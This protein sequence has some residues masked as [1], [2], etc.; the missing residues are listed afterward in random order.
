MTSLFIFHFTLLFRT[1][2]NR[3][4]CIFC[5][6]SLFQSFYCPVLFELSQGVMTKL[7]NGPLIHLPQFFPQLRMVVPQLS[8]L[9]YPLKRA[10]P[11]RA[12]VIYLI[13]AAPVIPAVI[14]YFQSLCFCNAPIH[15]RV[16]FTLNALRL[17]CC[18]ADI[19]KTFLAN[20]FRPLFRL[21]L[22][23]FLPLPVGLFKRLPLVAVHIK[24]VIALDRRTA[25]HIHIPFRFCHEAV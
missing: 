7:L 1:Q 23:I 17:V 18:N 15:Q 19:P 14:A 21:K 5:C 9:I 2:K 25:D 12:S 13:K 3:D 11:T 24:V 20:W 16:L 6:K 8:Q 4:L 10:A 22:V